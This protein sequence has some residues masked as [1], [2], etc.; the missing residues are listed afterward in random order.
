[1]SVK[2]GPVVALIEDEPLLRVPLAKALSE[3]GYRVIAAAS[4]LEGLALLDDP[5]IDVAIIDLR[6]PGRIDGLTLATEARRQHPGLGVIFASAGAPSDEAVAIGSFLQKPFTPDELFDA[7]RRCL[8][9]RPLA[10][11]ASSAD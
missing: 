2:S 9:A 4:G 7:I 10:R 3:A 5:G 6:L 1:M 8:A 11:R